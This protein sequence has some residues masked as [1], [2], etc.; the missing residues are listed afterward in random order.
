MEPYPPPPP[1]PAQTLPHRPASALRVF[2]TGLHNRIHGCLLDSGTGVRSEGR[3]Q[4]GGRCSFMS[5]LL[6]G[7]D[8][9]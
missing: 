7:L 3:V 5:M 2:V 1:P 8:P 4:K 9:T 6:S